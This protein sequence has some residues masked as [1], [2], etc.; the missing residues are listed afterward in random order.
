MRGGDASFRELALLG[1]ERVPTV[2]RPGLVVR[3]RLG[4]GGRR[5]R[6]GR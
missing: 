1:V 6:I 4:F 2:E 5:R 3:D